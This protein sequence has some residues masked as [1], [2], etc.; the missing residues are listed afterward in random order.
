MLQ[1]WN[2]N[3]RHQICIHSQCQS[4]IG[5]AGARSRC[6][7]GDD[8][9]SRHCEHGRCISCPPL[10]GTNKVVIRNGQCQDGTEGAGC[11]QNEDCLP[12]LGTEHRVCRDNRCSS[13]LIGSACG[14]DPDCVSRNCVDDHCRLGVHCYSRGPNFLQLSDRVQDSDQNEDIEENLDTSNEVMHTSYQFVESQTATSQT[15][16]FNPYERFEL[17]LISFAPLMTFTKTF[18]QTCAKDGIHMSLHRCMV[19]ALTPSA[20]S[21]R[22]GVTN[23]PPTTNHQPVWPSVAIDHSCA[24]SIKLVHASVNSTRY[25]HILGDLAVVFLCSIFYASSYVR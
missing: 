15:A 20:I 18:G 5:K 7:R 9:K 1:P 25:R 22:S 12:V 19:H 3:H 16:K 13:G 23:Q 10:R 8:C 17:T 2:R 24:S 21:R 11:G 4:G 14:Q 6:N